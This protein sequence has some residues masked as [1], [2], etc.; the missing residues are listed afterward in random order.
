MAAPYPDCALLPARCFNAGGISADWER[1]SQNVNESHR[2]AR[3][4]QA[5][6]RPIVAFAV[7]P[8]LLRHIRHHL[9]FSV[10]AYK[11]N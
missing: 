11:V 7:W 9:S 8:E 2:P 10:L 5:S 3:A 6:T 1:T 4:Y